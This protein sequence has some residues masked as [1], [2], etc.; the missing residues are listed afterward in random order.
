MTSR[1]A[2]LPIPFALFAS[3]LQE[4]YAGALVAQAPTAASGIL[5]QPRAIVAT[6]DDRA[7]PFL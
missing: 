5:I 4:N 2:L 6:T 1:H 3:G 7:R